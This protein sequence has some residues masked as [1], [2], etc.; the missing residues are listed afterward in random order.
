MESDF[1]NL[2]ADA[3][4]T[5]FSALRSLSGEFWSAIAGAVVGGAIAYLIQSKSLRDT[6]IERD[7]ERRLSDQNLGH[8]LFYKVLFIHRS[9]VDTKIKVDGRIEFGRERDVDNIVALLIPMLHPPTQIHFTAGEMAMLLSLK[10]SEVFNAVFGLDE[11]HNSTIHTWLLYKQERKIFTDMIA[12]EGFDSALG[13]GAVSVRK[14]SRAEIQHYEVEQIAHTLVSRSATDVERSTKSLNLLAHLLNAE[15]GAA[16]AF[17][18]YA[19]VASMA[20]NGSS[21]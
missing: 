3:G 12:I 4:L 18:S 2:V 10:D 1:I 6:R 19:S 8:S 5:F 17:A 11:I 9:C 16:P 13:A 14:G 7:R 21:G 15:L 20:P